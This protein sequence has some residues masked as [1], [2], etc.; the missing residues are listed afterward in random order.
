M[1]ACGDSE[2]LIARALGV[3]RHTLAKHCADELLN[4]WAR[5]RREVLDAL[6][7]GAKDGNASLIKRAEEMTRL[8]GAKEEAQDPARR[9]VAVPKLGKKE[10]LRQEALVAGA[11]NEWGDDLKPPA[12]TLN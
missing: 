11:G 7:E 5:R 10:I 2:D 12:D 6:F 3:D 9:S 4:G 8:T 1:R